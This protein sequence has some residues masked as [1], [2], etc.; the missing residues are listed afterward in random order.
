M[1]ELAPDLILQFQCSFVPASTGGL[2][3]R[4]PNYLMKGNHMSIPDTFTFMTKN[5]SNYG[6]MVSDFFSKAGRGR[7]PVQIDE[8]ADIY[9]G[10]YDE[11]DEPINEE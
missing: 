2:F 1:E 11:K 6:Y 8:D 7:G 5:I 10:Y 4:P 9:Y 3:M